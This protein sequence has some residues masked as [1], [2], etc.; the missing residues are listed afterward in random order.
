M[1]YFLAGQKER[2]YDLNNAPFETV[3]GGFYR[4][5][6]SS[7]ANVEQVVMTTPSVVI[8]ALAT[9]VIECDILWE[10]DTSNVQTSFRI[11]QTNLTGTVVRQGFTLVNPSASSGPYPFN[12]KGFYTAG[13]SATTINFVATTQSVTTGNTFI[14][15]SSSLFVKQLGGSSVTINTA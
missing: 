9:V 11:R 8:P 10:I 6:N 3:L 1:P 4:T 14:M 13:V 7:S 2:A 12:M 5:S 15:P